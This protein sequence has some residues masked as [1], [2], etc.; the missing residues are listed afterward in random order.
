MYKFIIPIG[1]FAPVLTLAAVSG[2]E[3]AIDLVIDFVSALIPFFLSLG[4]L[5]FFWGIVKF[6]AH[7]DDQKAREEGKRV[8]IWGMV[9]IFV[10]VSLWALVGFI[11]GSLGLGTTGT[12]GA[13]PVLPTALPAS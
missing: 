12:L 4:I 5:V 6:I 13:S 9:A 8:M 3:G 7:T 1:I 10:M 11:Q 2:V